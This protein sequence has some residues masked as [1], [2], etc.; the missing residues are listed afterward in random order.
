[1]R[2]IV[3]RKLIEAEQVAK[4]INVI[5]AP[6]S[7][8]AARK[9]FLVFCVSCWKSTKDFFQCAEF[10]V[11]TTTDDRMDRGNPAEWKKKLQIY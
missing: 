1:M 6:K 3:W 11:L 7:E 2:K 4:I 8:A 10:F 9:I 5:E